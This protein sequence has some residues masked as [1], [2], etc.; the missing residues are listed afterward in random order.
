MDL[1]QIPAP[2]LQ[3]RNRELL[4]VMDRLKQGGTASMTREQ[5]VTEKAALQAELRR[6]GIPIRPDTRVG[7][8]QSKLLSQRFVMTQDTGAELLAARDE[9]ERLRAEN[10]RLKG[11]A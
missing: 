7:T 1:E 3:A 5:C 4:Q 11:Q 6:R 10:A 8:E 2:D 9:N